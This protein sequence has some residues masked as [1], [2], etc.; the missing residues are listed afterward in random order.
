[1][2]R[3]RGIQTGKP[4]R[5][6]ADDGHRIVVDEDLLADHARIAGEA[7]HPVVVAKDDDRMTG[8][9]AVVFL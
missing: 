6:H 7:A 1:L 8:V 9:D 4:L 5:R 3:A 2:R